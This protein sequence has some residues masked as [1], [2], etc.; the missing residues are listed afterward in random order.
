M[1]GMLQ[2]YGQP[3]PLS[4]SALRRDIRSSA[5]H[6]FP[7]ATFG[8]TAQER[9]FHPS[10]FLPRIKRHVLPALFNMLKLAKLI[11]VRP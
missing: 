5:P 4:S 8:L 3:Q 10:P 9:I 2:A 7:F 11:G 1:G 6:G